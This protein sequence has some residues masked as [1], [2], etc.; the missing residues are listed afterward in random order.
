MFKLFSILILILLFNKSLESQAYLDGVPVTFSLNGPVDYTPTSGGVAIP[1]YKLEVGYS[2]HQWI[3]VRFM[4]LTSFGNTDVLIF[5]R[6]VNQTA[7]NYECTVSEHYSTSVRQNVLLTDTINR[8]DRAVTSF[9]DNNDFNL[10]IYRTLGTTNGE[11][12]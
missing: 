7:G 10:E 1:G 3:G 8:M 9:S 2:K 6:S 4:D 12:W 11:D 5:Q